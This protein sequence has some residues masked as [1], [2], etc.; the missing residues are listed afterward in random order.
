MR[1]SEGDGVEEPGPGEMAPDN[2]SADFCSFYFLVSGNRTQAVIFIFVYRI[3]ILGPVNQDGDR[4]GEHYSIKVQ[5][6]E[7]FLWSEPKIL[8]PP[9][10][11]S[12]FNKS[13]VHKL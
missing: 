6:P 12:S 13:L 11:K 9:G 4:G 8:R 2:S 5:R 3:Y 1:R 10:H 7:C